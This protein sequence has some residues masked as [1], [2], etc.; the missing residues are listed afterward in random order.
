MRRG[1]LGGHSKRETVNRQREG[2]KQNTIT[3]PGIILVD[4]PLLW[5][6]WLNASLQGHKL[7]QGNSAQPFIYLKNK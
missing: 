5:E 2:V 6:T 1:A 7:S 4:L 3:K